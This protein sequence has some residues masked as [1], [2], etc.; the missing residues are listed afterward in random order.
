MFFQ[1]QYIA[2][3]LYGILLTT[4]TLVTFRAIARYRNRLY[5]LRELLRRV[6]IQQPSQETSEQAA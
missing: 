1:W 5:L 4:F 6:I 3:L 2:T